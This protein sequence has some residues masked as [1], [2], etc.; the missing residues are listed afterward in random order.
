MEEKKVNPEMV[1]MLEK[2]SSKEIEKL[3]RESK[4]QEFVK[5]ILFTLRMVPKLK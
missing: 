2:L 4:D 5:E 1:N 3:Q